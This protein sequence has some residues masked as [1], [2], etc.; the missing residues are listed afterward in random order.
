MGAGL[1]DRTRR[2]RARAGG[3]PD[4]RARRPRDGLYR[5]AIANPPGARDLA[6]VN[7]AAWR[8]AEI[9]AINGHA[10]AAGVARF[11]A[12]LLAGGEL[13]GVR[14]VAPALVDAMR[15]GELTA[16]DTLFGDTITWGLG[17]WVDHDG[18]GMGGIGGSLGMADP[19]LEIAEAYVTRRMGTHDRA[20]AL[21]A[22]LRAALA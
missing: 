6:T 20:E 22:A 2:N 15:H 4:G 1:P 11:F 21:D 16:P 19:E 3:R 7:G 13:D 10:S 17:V 12:G 9:P 5:L 8:A 18:Y 14:L